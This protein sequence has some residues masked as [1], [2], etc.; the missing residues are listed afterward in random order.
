MPRPIALG[1]GALLKGD[2]DAVVTNLKDLIAHPAIKVPS[3]LMDT[4][5]SIILN[6]SEVNVK[7][8]VNTLTLNFFDLL[9]ERLPGTKMPHFEQCRPVF[10]LIFQV[11]WELRTGKF[12]LA[13][14]LLMKLNRMLY[15]AVDKKV[16]FEHNFLVD[17]IN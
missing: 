15:N 10:P 4:F 11:I 7:N 6:P 2:I 13:L 1:I 16:S 5:V 3:A 9:K 8:T 14:D 12:D 17:D